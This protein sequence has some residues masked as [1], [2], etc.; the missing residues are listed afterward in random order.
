MPL[1]N[2]LFVSVL[3]ILAQNAPGV[4]PLQTVAETSGFRSTAR[5]DEIVGLCRRLAAETEKA[6]YA[7]LGRSAEGRAL[8]MLILADPP[9]RTAEEAIRSGRLVVVAIG[10]IHGGEVCGKEALLMLAREIVREPQHRLLQE[11]VV[12]L[13]PVLNADGSE[14]IST[15]N[16]LQQ[17]GPENG[18]GRRT[19]ARGLDLNRD[20]VKLEAA[21]TRALVRFLNAWKPHLLIDTHTTNGSDH[22]Y[23]VLYEGPKHPAGDPRIIEYMR[24]NFFPTVGQTLEAATGIKSGYYGNFSDDRSS[25]V[26]FPAEVRYLTTY[27]GLRNRLSVLAEAYSKA[28][29]R[30]RV[31]ATRD[32]VREC[33]VQAAA[34]KSEILRLLEGAERSTVEAGKSP[35]VDQVAVRSEPQPL[36]NPKPILGYEASPGQ[37]PRPK[38][39]AIPLLLDFK[40]TETVSRP[41]AYLLPSNL[42]RVAATLQRHGIEL[43]E[44]REDIELEVE[45]NHITKIEEHASSSRDQGH[46]LSELWVTSRLESRRIPAGTWLVKTSQPLGSLAVVLLEPRSEDGFAAHRLF[47]DRIAPGAYYPVLRLTRPTAILTTEAESLVE[48]EQAPRRLV[49]FDDVHGSRGGGRFSGDP[50]SVQ[51]LDGEHWLQR[52]DD[53]LLM[54]EA[55]SGRS[56]PFVELEKLT[57]SIRQIPGMQEAAA[58]SLAQRLVAELDPARSMARRS[59]IELAPDRRG[60]LFQHEHDLHLARFDGGKGL[61]LTSDPSEEEHAQFSPDSRWVAFVRDFDLHVVDVET[62]TERAVTNGGSEIL[63]RAVADWVYFE[64]IF[65]RNW[66][67][68]WWSPDSR[69]IALMEFD[70]SAV[71]TLTMLNDTVEPR[72]VEV[73]RYPRAGSPNPKVRVGIADVGG[74]PVRWLDLSEYS[75]EAFLVSRVGWWPDSSAAYLYVQDR[76]QTWLDLLKVS[77]EETAPRPKRIFRDQT[78]AWIAEVE[79]VHFLKD[80]SFLWT[81]DRSGWRHL[82]HHSADGL[83]LSQIT[84]G[85]WEVRSVLHVDADAGRVYV[86]TT[87]DASTALQLD[88]L[89]LTGTTIERLTA[90][91]GSY[92]VLPSPNGKLFLTAWSNI[93]TPVQT[94][95]LDATGSLVRTVDSNPVHRL[96]NYRL[97]S[98][99]RLQIP[100]RDGFALEAE[101]ILPPDLDRTAKYPVWFMTYGGPQT[102]TIRDAWLGGRIWDH[103]LAAEGFV[104]FRMDPRSASGKGARSAWTAYKRLGVQELEDIHD[105]I[106]WLKQKPYVDPQRIGMSGHS[107]GGFMTAFAMTHSDLFAAGIA[108][109]PVTDWRDYDTIYTERFM[110]LPQDNPSGYDTTSVVKAARNLHGKLLLVHGAIDDNVSLRN[111]MRLVA[112]LQNANKD[113]ELMIYPGARHGIMNDHYFRL[114][115]DFIRRTLGGK[116]NS[117]SPKGGA[118]GGRSPLAEHPPLVPAVRASR[119][120]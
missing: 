4:D 60:I 19:N 111:T 102:P 85:P 90:G 117:D 52:K 42:E 27:Y 82:Y 93:H 5:H 47:E 53:Q 101:L 97:G 106:S 13:I 112:A 58:Q 109:A 44:L 100:S 65:N 39:Y 108:G 118:S 14:R 114:Q 55:R 29:Y 68:F 24:T 57:Q 119:I 91:A 66:S 110:G 92:Q 78:A 77:P 62:A 104:V 73:N 59:L 81:S 21:E 67:A 12:V 2:R 28:P 98:R 94:R 11:L 84:S 49:T 116:A 74:G 80:G 56:Q 23:L 89:S 32:F 95:L 17:D 70:D 115:I 99:E 88:R 120:P 43:R 8:P 79:A 48:E 33:L 34:R 54:V 41:F 10:G 105:A 22:R 46:Q 26:S 64:E 35:G 51:W 15:A 71:E 3:A 86:T 103:A 40:A 87:R 20:F 31:L 63:R 6:T 72:Q 18:A 45:V 113:F 50:V 83:L 96:K 75:A 38:D 16:R 36:S 37:D 30:D 107:Y 25:W 69:R 1:V 76:T 9:I 61:R 7:E